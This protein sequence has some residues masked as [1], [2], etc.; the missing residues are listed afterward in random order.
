MRAESR[1]DAATIRDDLRFLDSQ[2][3]AAPA[4]F[5]MLWLDACADLKELKA[6]ATVE[7]KLAAARLDPRTQ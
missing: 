4:I 1:A 2:T 7:T 3:K 6:D 5:R